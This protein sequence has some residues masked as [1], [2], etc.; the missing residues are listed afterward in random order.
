MI[1]G[2]TQELVV[3]VMRE[4]PQCLLESEMEVDLREFT[5]S[6]EDET[7]GS[8]FTQGE[9]EETDDEEEKDQ[10]KRAKK[11]KMKE[12]LTKEKDQEK[13]KASKK[14]E[15]KKKDKEREKEMGKK[16]ECCSDTVRSAEGL[17]YEPCAGPTKFLRALKDTP[18]WP[19]WSS[20]E[21]MKDGASDSPFDLY[22][23]LQ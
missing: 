23:C 17:A 14:K 8:D 4:F 7:E 9:E 20:V 21:R 10:G 12:K 6:D 5:V 11:G 13:V 18:L 16:K 22:P 1:V 19:M 2:W 15:L 3:V